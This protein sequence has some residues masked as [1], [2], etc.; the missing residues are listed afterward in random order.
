MSVTTELGETPIE[1]GLRLPSDPEAPGVAR[2]VVRELDGVVPPALIEKLALVS[3]ELVTNAL[4]HSP[5]TPTPIVSLRVEPG[6]VTLA[7]SSVSPA[8]DRHALIEDPGANGGFGLHLVDA[9]ADRW[10]VEHD[11]ATRV[12]CE[13]DF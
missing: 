5:G 12:I 13:F 2:A 3:S 1:L 4:R 6:R 8:F 9:L 10:Q 11:V 7:V